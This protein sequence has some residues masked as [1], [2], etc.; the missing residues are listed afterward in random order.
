MERMVLPE[1]PRKAAT[2][3]RGKSVICGCFEMVFKN[4]KRKTR[5]R[6]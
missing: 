3:I 2:M 6:F 5:P 4:K 1:P